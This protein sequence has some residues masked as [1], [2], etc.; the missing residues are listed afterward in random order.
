MLH[1]I[2]LV[3]KNKYPVCLARCY[4]HQPWLTRKFQQGD[5]DDLTFGTTSQRRRRWQSEK[6][7]SGWGLK[8]GE[9]WCMQPPAKFGEPNVPQELL[10]EKRKK[11]C[12][13]P[14]ES[15]SITCALASWADGS[16][17]LARVI[18]LSRLPI[19]GAASRQDETF[20]SGDHVPCPGAFAIRKKE[21]SSS[22]GPR[23]RLRVP[24]KL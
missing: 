5:Q 10:K 19:L 13:I 12:G 3:N 6:L 24:V 14:A 11:G 16:N 18:C 7:E 9:L 4:L 15:I 2:M 20:C 1:T 17:Q 8:S 22:F 23:Q 21:P